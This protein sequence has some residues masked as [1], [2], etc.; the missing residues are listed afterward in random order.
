[1]HHQSWT[2]LVQAISSRVARRLNCA[3]R[4]ER[5][6]ISILTVFVLLMFTMLLMMLFNVARHY[7]DKIRMQNA[8]DAAAYSGGAVL[9]RG[10]NAIAFTNH[11][12]ADVFAVTAFLREAR[13]RN[14]EG[15]VPEVLAAWV[16]SGQRFGGSPF[17]KFQGLDQSIAAKAPL[18]QAFVTAWGNMAYE[19]S[20]ALLPVF[21]HILGTPETQNP[22]ARD[23]LIPEFQRSVI[24]LTPGLAQ[25]MTLEMALRHGL[26]QTDLES[27]PSPIRYNPTYGAGVRGPQAGVLWR[28]TVLPVFLADETHPLWRTLPVVDPDQYQSDYLRVP[29]G[30]AYLQAARQR[31]SDRAHDYLTQWLADQDPARGL[32]Q[33][34]QYAAM[35]QYA[36]LFHA[37]ACGQLEILLND[38]YPNVNVPIMLREPQSAGSNEWIEQEYSYIGVVYRRHVD[39]N[40]PRMFRNPLNE[41]ADA[42]TFA[43]VTLFIPAPR[44]QCCPWEWPFQYFDSNTMS[45]QTGWTPNY[46]GWSND[47]S[48]FNQNWTVKLVPATSESLGE[49]LSSDP[50][51]PAS[52]YRRPNLR[53]VSVQDMQGVNTH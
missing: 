1:M 38:E 23:R 26:R 36:R 16:E 5:G 19:A 49:I 40:A 4:D 48:M 28:T 51:G 6:T 30:N 29:N 13:D 21:E 3:H 52:G 14:A 12:E 10:M 33:A 15:Y 41:G 44:R 25:E 53:S 17:P 31:R 34:D 45:W 50:G 7:D 20:Q 9:A 18:E 37:A 24:A 32:D 43:Q 27:L 11:L 47:W 39:E 35:S 22:Y 42:Q 8:A 46:D 2:I